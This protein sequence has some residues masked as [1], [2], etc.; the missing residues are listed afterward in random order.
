MSAPV[1]NETPQVPGDAWEIL[2][3]CR[4]FYLKQLVRLLQEA[5]ALP[6]EPLRAFVKAAGGYYDEI[7]FDRKAQPVRSA[8][9][10]DRFPDIAGRRG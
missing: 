2:R 5:E 3:D 4:V 6:E 7:V 9:Q 1:G 10:P 8:W